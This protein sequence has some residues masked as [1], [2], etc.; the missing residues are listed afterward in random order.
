MCIQDN[1][2]PYFRELAWKC[3]KL[4]KGKR[5]NDWWFRNENVFL[6]RTENETAKMICHKHDIDDLYPGFNYS[7]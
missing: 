5:I 7:G 6:K 2:S 3:R 1:L 4:K